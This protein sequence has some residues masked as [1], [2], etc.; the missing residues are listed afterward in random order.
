[1]QESKKPCSR[2]EQYFQ[3]LLNGDKQECDMTKHEIASISEA[4]EKYR[5][6]NNDNECP[7]FEE[8]KT[9]LPRRFGRSTGIVLIAIGEAMKFPGK[10]VKLNEFVISNNLHLT[11]ISSPILVHIAKFLIGKLELN[12]IKVDS[13]E[14][15]ESS[16]YGILYVPK[17][18]QVVKLTQRI[19]EH[20]IEISKET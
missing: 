9:F 15:I 19:P 10:K 13:N 14:C 11:D 8:R 17:L 2:C 6:I 1:M 5:K 7:Y 18:N 4:R 16:N 20:E 3:S 12:N